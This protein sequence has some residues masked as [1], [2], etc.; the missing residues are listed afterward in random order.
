M[1]YVL[2]SGGTYFNYDPSKSTSSQLVQL[3]SGTTQW[4]ARQ[5]PRTI[6]GVIKDDEATRPGASF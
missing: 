4:G 3:R 2:L 1:L 6:T 5:V